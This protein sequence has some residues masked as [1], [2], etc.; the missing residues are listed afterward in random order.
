MQPREGGG[1]ERGSRS[2]PLL[3]LLQIG[4]PLKEQRDPTA[5]PSETKHARRARA[6]AGR[7]ALSLFWLLHDRDDTDD[8]SVITVLVT[9]NHSYMQSYSSHG[10]GV[11]PQL[12]WRAP[13]LMVHDSH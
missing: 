11:G 5:S 12:M 10:G 3:W 7:G 8:L 13:L 1:A 4:F 9:A 6:G 2:A